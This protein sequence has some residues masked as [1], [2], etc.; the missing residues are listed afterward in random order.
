MTTLTNLAAVMRLQHT[1]R[2]APRPRRLR[3]SHV[4]PRKTITP[5][6]FGPPSPHHPRQAT[7]YRPPMGAVVSS[8]ATSTRV[9]ALDAVNVLDAL[10]NDDDDIDHLAVAIDVHGGSAIACLW[11]DFNRFPREPTLFTKVEND[12]WLHHLGLFTVSSMLENSKWCCS[13]AVCHRYPGFFEL[14]ARQEELALLEPRVLMLYP[15]F[16]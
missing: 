11:D 5:K 1:S 3:S 13:C 10:E 14:P 6:F 2:R 4:D 15:A 12:G 16:E 9:D 7:R 8:P